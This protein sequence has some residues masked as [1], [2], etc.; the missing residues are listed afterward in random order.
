MSEKH[1]TKECS[2]EEVLL[3]SALHTKQWRTSC[4]S[5][6]TLG[7]WSLFTPDRRLRGPQPILIQWY[8]EESQLMSIYP[9]CNKPH[10]LAEQS[11]FTYTQPIQTMLFVSLFTVLFGTAKTRK[12]HSAIICT[13]LLCYMFIKCWSLKYLEFTCKYYFPRGNHI[14]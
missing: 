13:T 9:V 10:P 12:S 1:N 14:K 2:K 11:Y 5:V 6:L 4:S 8:K 3:T 7:R